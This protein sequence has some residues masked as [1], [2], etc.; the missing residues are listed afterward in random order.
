MKA[1]LSIILLVPF[2]CCMLLETVT[3]EHP[4]ALELL[5]KY[6]QAL[7]S[8]ASFISSYELKNEYSGRIPAGHAFYQMYGGKEFFY[9]IFKCGVFKFKENKGFYHQQY[10]WG[11]FNEQLKNVSENK[12]ISR[13]WIIGKEFDYFHQVN[14]DQVKDDLYPAGMV[15]RHTRKKEVIE[16][17]DCSVGI[18]H[19]LGYLDTEERLDEVLREANRISVRSKTENIRGSECY[20][21]DADTKYG[22]F[23]I[24]FDPNHGYHPAKIKHKAKEG[25]YCN[26]H[27]IP[28]GSIATGYLDV[29]KSEQV[30]GIWVPMKVKAGYDR[31]IGSNKYYMKED[32]HYRRTRILLNPDHDKLGSFTD[33]ILE[34]PNNDPELVEGTHVRLDS[35]SAEYIWQDCKKFMVDEWD[36]SI[37]YVP[38]DWSI[39]VSSNKPLPGFEGIELDLPA[40]KTKDK[41]IL[42]CFFNMEQRSSRNCLRQLS[43]K[44]Q[45]SPERSRRE[46][47]AKDIFVV[48]VQASRIEREKLDEWVKENEIPFPVGMIKNDEEKTRFTWGVRSLPWL[49]LT[50]KDHI[51]T[52]EGFSLADLD[53][54]IRG[55][56]ED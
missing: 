44:A 46:L 39:L 6:T 29:L 5:D 27:R 23:S 56:S 7:D 41:A 43:T 14:N 25:E 24:W 19:I 30:A 40:E 55:N 47:E 16:A 45:A 9:K 37:K 31:T 28:E 48:A 20:V 52:T 35:N 32:V 22:R 18:S 42:L 49:I 50:D 2:L 26:H 34:N 54:K 8:T 33:P 11:Y 51:V 38:K 53:K 4:T 3:A 17:P 1:G 10:E 15:R 21:I 13:L 12:P 36:G